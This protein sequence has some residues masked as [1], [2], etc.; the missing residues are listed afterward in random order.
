MRDELQN[1]PAS[2]ATN[3]STLERGEELAEAALAPRLPFPV[4]GI[5]AS[6]GG[7]EAFFELFDAM[8]S[9]TGAAFVLVQHLPPDRESLLAELLQ[10]RT[11]MKVREVVDGM[12]VEPNH[13]Y[14][15]RPGR[16]LTLRDGLLRLGEPVERRG[17]ARP[18]DD[19]FRSLAEEQRE[20]AICIVMSGM[21]SNG[22]AGAQLVK[23]VGGP[24]IA[25]D[26]L[27]ASNEE[28]TSVNEELQSTN[29]ELETS[30]EELQSLNEEL[31][32]LNAQL[33]VKMQEHET[34]TSD[35]SSLLRSTDIAVLFLDRSFQIRKFT[36]AV[37]DLLDLIP[38]DIGRPL[39]HL[40]PKF[41]D[42]DLLADAAAVLD[43]LVPIE[44]EVA[45]ESRRWYARRILPYRTSDNRLDGVVITFVDIT[46]RKHGELSLRE[47]ARLLDL[48]NDAIIVRNL[49]DEI[50]SWNQGATD[51]FGWSSEEAVGREA[52]GLLKSV[53]EPSLNE[54]VELLR[55]H[56]R[57]TGEVVQTTRDGR[58][59]TSLVRWALD[60]SADG[61]PVAILTSMN[62]ITELKRGAET[63]QEREQQFRFLVEEAHDFALLLLDA[64]GRITAWNVGAE[65]LLGFTERDVLGHSLTMTFPAEERVLS[66]F[67][68]VCAAA[69]RD[70]RTEDARWHARKDG[71]RFFGTGVIT[72]VRGCDG[73]VRGFVKVVRDDTARKL[74]EDT[75]LEAAA[76]ATSANRMKDE[77]LATLSHELRTPLGAIQLWVRVL[78]DGPQD[79]ESRARGLAAIEKSVKAQKQLI[80]DLLDTSRIAA[81]TLRVGLEECDLAAKLR[82]WVDAVVPIAEVK[83]V[84]VGLAIAN[85]VGTVATDPDRL[86]QVVCRD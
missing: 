57:H 38:T 1:S 60:R 37:R 23:A 68:S 17:Q 34:A 53:G 10:A 21:G 18:V 62:D 41:S 45:S 11:A 29:E 58:K 27:R 28:A 33:H 83:G 71:S 2:G 6:A 50:V 7:L 63:L 16:T 76:R 73:I 19:F 30:K 86:E 35:L 39:S 40:A 49:N 24:C 20:R 5:G 80:D 56:E 48:T 85:D 14:V 81:G 74:A 79:A 44:K 84:H 64:E 42:P 8:P 66:D 25:Q 3:D 43:R 9:T 55:R 36:P 67:S 46:S 61:E 82:S 59:I 47:K 75:L 15:I 72:V 69:V 54:L 22:S 51:K 26:Q 78:A 52:R 65:R 32:T 31:S 12:P 70:G 77:L 13:L 4:V